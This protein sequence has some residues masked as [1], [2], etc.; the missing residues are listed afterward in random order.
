MSQD[1]DLTVLSIGSFRRRMLWT[2]WFAAGS[3]MGAFLW[4]SHVFNSTDNIKR[5]LSAA[6]LALVSVVAWASF[7]IVVCMVRMT[8]R[9]LRA[10]ELLSRDRSA[11]CP[12]R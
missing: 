8:K 5:L 2:G 10:I 11:P 12:P 4:F 9:I 6:V 1:I 3:S 7:A